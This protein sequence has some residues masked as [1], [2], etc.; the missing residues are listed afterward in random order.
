MCIFFGWLRAAQK[1]GEDFR[2]GSTGILKAKYGSMH[3][4]LQAYMDLLEQM[5]LIRR[6]DIHILEEFAHLVRFTGAKLQV[7]GKDRELGDGTLHSL[8]VK[9][10]PDCEL[11]NYSCWLNECA[12]EKSVTA[13]RDWVKDEVK[14]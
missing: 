3:Q 12:R 6:N 13:F 9:K 2:T 7:E 1:N 8:L 14:F 5:P 11:E 4:L 10:L